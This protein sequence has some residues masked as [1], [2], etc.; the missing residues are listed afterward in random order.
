MA[1]ALNR[2][3]APRH[4]LATGVDPARQRRAVRVADIETSK[5]TASE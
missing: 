1:E 4:L 5:V 3:E 2:R